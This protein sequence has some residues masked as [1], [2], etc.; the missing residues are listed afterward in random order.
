MIEKEDRT[1]TPPLNTEEELV[2]ELQYHKFWK[3][4]YKKSKTPHSIEETVG[5]VEHDEH[6]QLYTL[7]LINSSRNICLELY[8][9]QNGES[10]AMDLK[11]YCGKV[12]VA[13]RVLCFDAF[14]PVHIQLWENYKKERAMVQCAFSLTEQQEKALSM[15]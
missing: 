4:Y 6:R 5:F 8:E 7:Q 12:I 11:E 14:F 10:V 2:L 3:K 13:S 15:L 9:E 1:L